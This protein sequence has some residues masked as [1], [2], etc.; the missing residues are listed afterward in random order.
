[1]RVV[2]LGT[3]TDVGKTYV[4]VALVRELRR[5]DPSRR[6]LA[7]KP[8]ESG[9]ARGVAMDAR[10]LEA[11]APDARYPSPH[12]LYAF[13]PPISPHLAARHVNITIDVERIA[14]WLR[15]V[16]ASAAADSIYVVETAGGVFSPLTDALTNLD[17]A[18][19]LEP[20]IWLLVVPDAL[21]A[22]HDSRATLMAM[23]QAARAP[24]YVVVN[25]A[26]EPDAATGTTA[27]ELASLG[28][29]QPA[30]TLS[31]SDTHGITPLAA[32]LLSKIA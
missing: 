17:L 9:V 13:E 7:L 18:H 10:A 30:A 4:G 14:G 8:V 5:L 25:A 19:A 31:R 1:M 20:A 27:R 6:V 22:L 12:P 2:L 16:E 11:A 26:R 24:D 23:A 29:A 3:G 32:L 21:G 15:D 28:L